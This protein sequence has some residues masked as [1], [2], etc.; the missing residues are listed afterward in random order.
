[1]DCTVDVF[2]CVVCG[3][4]LP[5]DIR[6]SVQVHHQSLEM[7]HRP[8]CLLVEGITDKTCHTIQINSHSQSYRMQTSA[9]MLQAII[10]FVTG[11]VVEPSANT[12]ISVFL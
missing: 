3:L 12:Y 2:V 1:M 6:M 8:S 5:G 10:Q 9:S 11:D 4:W 7:M